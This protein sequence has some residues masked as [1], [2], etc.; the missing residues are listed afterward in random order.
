MNFEIFYREYEELSKNNNV[1]TIGLERRYPLNMLQ[2]SFNLDYS[3]PLE[4]GFKDYILCQHS[5]TN[6]IQE[7]VSNLNEMY[8]RD[9]FELYKFKTTWSKQQVFHPEPI[10]NSKKITKNLYINVNL[11]ALHA[12]WLIQDLFDYYGIKP[13][14]TFVVVHQASKGE[15]EPYKSQIK[16]LMIKYFRIFLSEEKKQS[17]E[18][19][20]KII[21]II[22]IANKTLKK[23]PVAYNDFFL[24]DNSNQFSS[25]KSLF[26]KKIG[27]YAAF[28]EK[29]IK[30]I[31]YCLGL[32]SDFYSCLNREAKTRIK[33][34]VV[35]IS[36][37]GTF[38]VFN[39]Q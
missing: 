15:L 16:D 28:N 14:E 25:Y 2:K 27:K 33:K 31:S 8:P 26:F 4:I 32:L 24:F 37:D 9:V 38:H 13:E 7:L 6:I 5:W 3:T 11:T 21:H 36:A 17:E 39:C 19:I 30:Q 22:D 34:R 18:R 29:Q 10:T 35:S 12:I 20:G 1:L 23:M